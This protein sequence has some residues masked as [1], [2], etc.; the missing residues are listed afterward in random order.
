MTGPAAAD[1]LPT[2]DPARADLAGGYLALLADVLKDPLVREP[3]HVLVRPRGTAADRAVATA[4]SL[5]VRERGPLR[6]GVVGDES[7]VLGA[8]EAGSPVRDG[9]CLIAVAAV[10][11]DRTAHDVPVTVYRSMATAGSRIVHLRRAGTGW[12]VRTAGDPPTAPAPGG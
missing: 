12:Q 3:V 1:N 4:V 5:L 11:G 9:G 8:G 2:A 7:E 10:T 6:I